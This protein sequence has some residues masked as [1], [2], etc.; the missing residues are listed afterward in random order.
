MRGGARRFEV[1]SV[2]YAS[3]YAVDAALSLLSEVGVP[4]IEAHALA[5]AGRLRRGMA[6][7]GLAVPRRAFGP[8]AS[9]IV[10]VG[11]LGAGGHGNTTDPLLVRLSDHL[12][13]HDVEH[14]IRRG[15]LRFAFHLFNSDADVDPVLHLTPDLLSPNAAYPRPPT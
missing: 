15:M 6:E 1:G 10:T 14:T 8:E 12:A 7:L 9:H 11:Q 4:A 13:A 5:L 2:D 3:C